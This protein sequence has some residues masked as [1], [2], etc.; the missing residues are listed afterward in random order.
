MRR[1]NRGKPLNN[2]LVKSLVFAAAAFA[3]GGIGFALQAAIPAGLLTGAKGMVGSVAGV[4]AL[5]LA[6]VL[7][8]VVWTSHGVYTG[9]VTQAQALGPIVLQLDHL[10]RRLGSAGE[11]G[12]V[13]LRDQVKRHRERFWGEA[14]HTRSADAH[15]VSRAATEAMT[16]FF[17]SL[18][19]D[20]PRVQ[21]LVA[22]ARPLSASMIQTQLLMAR[23][24]ASPLAPV[25]LVVVGGWTLLLFF[26]YG[27]SSTPNALAL[28]VMGLGTLAVASALLLI[29]KLSA[30]YEGAFRISPAGIDQVLAAIDVKIE[31]GA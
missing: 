16:E 10:L 21:A 7:G 26:C 5:L 6:L 24:L 22:A 29:F 18:P 17:D 25:L 23:Q 31:A 3:S 8:L 4:V 30:P 2:P 9:Q 13:L 12:R 19:T 28:F 20:S 27:L 15:A 11:P 14:R 1:Q